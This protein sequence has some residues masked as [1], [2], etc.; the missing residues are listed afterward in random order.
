M[1][2]PHLLFTTPVS[3]YVSRRLAPNIKHAPDTI[4]SLG[5]F[6]LDALDGYTD[7]VQVDLAQRNAPRTHAPARSGLFAKLKSLATSLPRLA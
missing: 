4:E 3:D 7:A 6:R 5:R 2:I 1:L